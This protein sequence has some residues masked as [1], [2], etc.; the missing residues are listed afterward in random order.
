MFGGKSRV[1]HVCIGGFLCWM[2]LVAAHSEESATTPCHYYSLRTRRR[3]LSKTSH[4]VH[5]WNIPQSWHDVQQMDPIAILIAILVVW[6]LCCVLC[7]LISCL[8]AWF[9]SC[10]LFCCG[11][12]STHRRRRR[13][14]DYTSLDSAA[15][16]RPPPYNPAYNPGYRTR[17]RAEYQYYDPSDDDYCCRNTLWAL[18]C[19]ECCCRDNRDFEC[20]DICCGLCLYEMCCPRR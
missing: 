18:C 8:Y 17:H 1:I 14:V 9:C 16:A 4:F 5:D 10:F 11:D 15:A 20:C 3:S 13:R 12:D 6:I 7:N 19:L 2:S